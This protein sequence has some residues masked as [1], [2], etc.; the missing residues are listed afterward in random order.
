MLVRVAPELACVDFVVFEEEVS[1]AVDDDEAGR[2]W[3]E[4]GID[5]AAEGAVAAVG[6][7][8]AFGVV[9]ERLLLAFVGEEVGDAVVLSS[10]GWRSGFC[11]VVGD[12]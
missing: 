5:R 10:E 12:V 6:R 4:D 7:D 1:L 2:V 11:A 9:G 3:D 8:V